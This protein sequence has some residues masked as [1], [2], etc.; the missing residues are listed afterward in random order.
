MR[1]SIFLLLEFLQFFW[2]EFGRFQV[3][4]EFIVVRVQ[5]LSINI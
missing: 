5:G 2:I 3:F 1:F 4:M